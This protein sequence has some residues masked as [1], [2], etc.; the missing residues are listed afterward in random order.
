MDDI[1]RMLE[2][3]KSFTNYGYG[4]RHADDSLAMFMTEDQKLLIEY[5]E[6]FEFVAYLQKVRMPEFY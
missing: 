2:N 3:K 1:V 5:S 6:T 4:E